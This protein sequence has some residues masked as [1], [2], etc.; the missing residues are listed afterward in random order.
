[1]MTMSIQLVE[2]GIYESIERNIILLGR[3]VKVMK[4][5]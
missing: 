1:M 5:N 2:N 3:G 4:V